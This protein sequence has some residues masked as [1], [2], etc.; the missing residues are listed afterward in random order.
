MQINASIATRGIYKKAAMFLVV[1]LGVLLDSA[2]HTNMIRT[3]FIGA[4]AIIEA[5]SIVEN[6]DKAG[7]GAYIPHFLRNTLAQIAREKHIDER[8]DKHD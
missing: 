1:G 7:F 2:M 4:F 3:L 5:M 6:I 8:S